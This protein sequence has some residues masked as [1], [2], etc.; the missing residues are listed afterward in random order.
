MRPTRSIAALLAVLI[1]L[2]A[3]CASDP[4]GGVKPIVR[5][6]ALVP[7][8]NPKVLTYYNRNPA[9]V[10]SPLES[11][12]RSQATK[13]AAADLS[14]TYQLETLAL[15]EKLT[16]AVAAELRKL[17]FEVQIV[18][19]VVRPKEVPDNIDIRTIQ[20]EADAILQVSISDMG[21]YSPV[22]NALFVPYLA[23]YGLMYPKGH[24][25]PIFDSDTQF[26][27]YAEKG[28]DW[29]IEIDKQYYGTMSPS[30][31]VD[32]FRSLFA[33]GVAAGGK[34]MAQRIAAKLK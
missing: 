24:R 29:A 12:A 19:N 25:R 11:Y 10:K 14:A 17:G 23:A 30:S 15:G 27:A 31:R 26:G 28:Q 16:E 4:G 34:R 20:I 13:R 8:S 3:G 21:F 5:S 9:P 32:E 7:A 6:I 33:E 22:P 18:T 2:V 1:L